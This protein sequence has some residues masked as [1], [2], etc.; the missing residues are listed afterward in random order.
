MNMIFNYDN[1]KEHDNKIEQLIKNITGNA[2]N[3]GRAIEPNAYEGEDLNHVV[4]LYKNI[5]KKKCC[6][7][8]LINISNYTTGQLS[9]IKYKIKESENIEK[10]NDIIRKEYEEKEKNAID[11]LKTEMR[12][13]LIKTKYEYYKFLD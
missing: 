5:I 13:N 4:K 2:L 8:C 7:D 3:Y 12:E 9:N 11:N 1:N 10:E 6:D